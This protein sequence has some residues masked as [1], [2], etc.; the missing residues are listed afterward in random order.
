MKRILLC[1]ISLSFVFMGCEETV[2][3]DEVNSMIDVETEKLNDNED[4]TVV[5]T[6]YSVT[7]FS[8]VD[9]STFVSGKW[10]MITERD[11]PDSSYLYVVTL[12]DDTLVKEYE[13]VFIQMGS[14]N[15]CSLG[16]IV[17][18]SKGDYSDK[19]LDSICK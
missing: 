13:D 16:R 6:K 15:T 12:E 9:T 19:I 1:I 14:K 18:A 5:N 10:Y 11:N 8:D 17:L 4:I 3:I 7:D 2:S